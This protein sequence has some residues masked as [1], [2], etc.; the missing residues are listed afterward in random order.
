M[1]G[2]L[3]LIDSETVS[4]STTAVTL[5]G[6][7]STY[8]VY[9]LQIAGMTVSADEA[10][11]MR[12]TKSGSAQTDSNYD[13]AKEYFKSDTSFS[14]VS[15]QNVDR[16]DCT[17][18][19]DS[20]SGAAGN[21]TYYLFNFPNASEY[22]FVTIESN[23]LQATVDSVRGFQGGFVHTVA[24]ASDGIQISANNWT[25]SSTLEAGEFKLYGLNK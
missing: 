1:A 14:T 20:G 16:I 15:Q 12:V 22:S 2:S 10:P 19:I 5:T 24:S 25:T 7:D 6:I 8:N 11:M 18:T 3:V 21:G 9:V 17:A 23:H 13:E 4:S